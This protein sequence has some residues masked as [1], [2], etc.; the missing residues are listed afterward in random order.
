MRYRDFGATGM[1]VSEVGFGSWAI[2]GR[3]YG[4]V[5]RAESIDALA[6]AEELGCN[7][8][9]T[10][11]VYGDAEEVIGEFLVSRRGKW[12]VA[13]KYSG[14]KPGLQA[15]LE[16][17]LRRLRVDTIDFYQIHWAPGR[18]EHALYEDL[19]RA[20]KSGKVRA[21]GVSL[22]NEQDIDHILDATQID[23]FQIKFSLLDPYPFLARVARIREH[24][25]AVVV[26]S[27]LREGFLAGKFNAQ[28][29]FTDPDDQRSK[30]TRAE[31]VE[32]VDAAERFRFLEGAAGSM[33][34]G[35]A[36]YPLSFPE[37]STVLMGTK[38]GAQAQANFG[39]VPGA[40]LPSAILLQV[41]REQQALGLH[42]R[43]RAMLDWLRRKLPR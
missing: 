42:S 41:Y 43:G 29:T 35:A 22:K 24:K 34:I 12:L 9:D 6:H 7:F 31:I 19:Y 17:Q 8:V 37:V 23:G 3:A 16:T 39:A 33:A 11:M 32:L 38:S 40:T 18:D 10:A 14:Q 25:P 27:S 2:G 20:K 21:V 15:T 30:L 1:K 4:R 26:R 5:A 28:S 13:S 36:R